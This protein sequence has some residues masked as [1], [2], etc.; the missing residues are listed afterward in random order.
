MS[1]LLLHTSSKR[2]TFAMTTLS[3]GY[4]L[5][6]VVMLWYRHRLYLS[7]AVLSI[8]HALSWLLSREIR[9]ATNT[10]HHILVCSVMKLRCMDMRIDEINYSYISNATVSSRSKKD[11]T[12][13]IC[14]KSA[15]FC[16]QNTK[17]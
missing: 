14:K 4:R 13:K 15:L 11:P 3:T 1:A 12:V 16:I 2:I 7:A 9:K 8:R 6:I 5:K 17:G 10:L